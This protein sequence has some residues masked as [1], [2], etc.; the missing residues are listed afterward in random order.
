MKKIESPSIDQNIEIVRCLTYN[1]TPLSI[2]V[3][4]KQAIC[5]YLLY[6]SSVTG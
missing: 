4:I 2:A 1:L 5:Y 3:L 6:S